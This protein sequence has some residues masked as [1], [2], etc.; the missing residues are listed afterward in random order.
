MSEGVALGVGD[1]VRLGVKDG[2]R[3]FVGDGVWLGVE[4]GLRVFVG[5]GVPVGVS[6]GTVLGVKDG[7]RL[8]VKDG[9][10]AGLCDSRRSGVP[11]SAPATSAPLPTS[12]PVAH[13]QT[14]PNTSAARKAVAPN[15]IPSFITSPYLDDCRPIRNYG[16]SNGGHYNRKRRLCHLSDHSWQVLGWRPDAVRSVSGTRATEL[17]CELVRSPWPS[18]TGG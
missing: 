12:R 17:P 10:A 8:G 13:E 15:L 2:A 3:V 1:G 9:T 6:E 7:V 14:K 16:W 5:D 11:E 4:D 18:G